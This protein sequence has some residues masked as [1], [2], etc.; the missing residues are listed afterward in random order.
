MTTKDRGMPVPLMD[1]RMEV[2][3]VMEPVCMM[4]I[5]PL[6]QNEPE[7]MR[8]LH[9]RVVFVSSLHRIQVKLTKIMAVG[10]PSTWVGCRPHS[11]P[12]ART[13]LEAL[14]QCH[15]LVVL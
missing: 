14:L 5:G 12:H 8:L 2:I 4:P 9:Q 10:I 1:I 13:V 3:A 11:R 6:R 7:L 15:G